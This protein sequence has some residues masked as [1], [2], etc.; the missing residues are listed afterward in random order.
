[1]QSP[2]EIAVPLIVFSTL[3]AIIGLLLWY[4]LT[5]KRE[6]LRF[7]S[8]QSE[9]TPSAINALG[10]Q[11]FSQRNDR[12]KA[13]FLILIAFAL[14]SFSFIVEFPHRGNLDLN[15]AIYGLGLFPFFSGLA[16]LIIDRLE[17]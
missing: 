17:R 9:I 2:E 12:R 5:K 1:M 10:R 4:Q 14:W 15:E 7:L 6:F 11:Y 16:Y 3:T 13:V 8:K